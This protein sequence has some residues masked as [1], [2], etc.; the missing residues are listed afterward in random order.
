MCASRF[1]TCCITIW[2]TTSTGRRRCSGRWWPRGGWGGRAAAGSM[3]IAIEATGL[4][5]TQRQIVDLAREFARTRIEPHAAEWDRTGYFP[6]D[7][8]DELGRLGFLGMCTPEAFDG[9]GL[10]TLTY[11]LALEEIAAADASIAISVSIHNAI[12]TTML[13]RHGS[14]AQQERWLRSMARGERLAGFALSEPESGSDAGAL[15]ARA[16]RDGGARRGPP[17]DRGPGRRHRASGARARRRLLRR[18]PAV[19]RGAAGVRGGAV[20]AGGHGHARGGRPRPHPRGRWS[21]RPERGLHD[22]GEHGQAVR[23]RDRD[24]GHDTGGAAVRRLRLHAGLP[25]REAVP[26]CEGHGAL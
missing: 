2:A 23:V 25:G 7:V 1:S 20:Q 16:V 17:G 10:D 11:F 3:S 9:M 21:H 15:A 12:P 8:L 5:E 18:T 26:G 24:V 4:S 19:R 13:V 22:A 14:A 6:R